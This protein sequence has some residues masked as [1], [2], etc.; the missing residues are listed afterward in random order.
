MRALVTGGTGFIGSHLVE[1]LIKKGLSVR[2]LVRDPAR[3]G[4]LEALDVELVKGD[5]TRPDT[6]KGVTSGVDYVFHAAGVTKA[7]DAGTYDLINGEGTRYLAEAAVRDAAGL[8]KFVYV[9]SQAAAGPSREGRP[10]REEDPPEPVSDYGRSKLLGEEYLTRLKDELNVVFVRPTSVYGPRD[11]DIYTFFKLVNHRLRTSFREKRLVSLCY[12]DDLVDGILRSAFGETVSG[13]AFFFA[14]PEPYDWDAMG[15]T[16]ALALGVKARRV[17]LPIPLLSVVAV[18]A[19]GA[20]SL[21]GSPAL[22]NRQKMAEIRQRYW[23]VDVNKAK[24]K[25]GF[26]ARHDFESGAKLTADWYRQNGWL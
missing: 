1:A 16:I 5:C 6:L 24:S 26:T 9:S 12:V 20:A 19:E 25:L 21:T 7:N 4:W 8:K 18:M 13:E 23:V 3:P 22:L 17:V 10:R 2:C 15:E 11:R 14:W